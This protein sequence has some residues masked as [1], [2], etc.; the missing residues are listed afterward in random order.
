[1]TVSEHGG[2]S[3]SASSATA[4]P[5]T[6]RENIIMDEP[7]GLSRDDA[8]PSQSSRTSDPDGSF[9]VSQA[10]TLSPMQDDSWTSSDEKDSGDRRMDEQVEEEKGTKSRD[11]ARTD[12]NMSIAETLSLPREILFVL[13]I[14]LA[15]LFTQSG[16]GQTI[17]IIHTIGE[18]FGITNPGE[19]SWFMA[20]YSLTIGTFI[21]FSGRL[22][23]VFGHKTL[24]LYGMG[25]Y[26]I[27]SIVCG[28]SVY[29][30]HVL[31]IFA[32]VLQ[33]IGPAIILP[34]GLAILGVTYA[35]GRRKEMIFAIFGA[36]APTGSVIGSLFAA[37]LALAWWPWAFWAF[38]IVLAATVVIGYYAI[39]EASNR[40]H[41]QPKGFKNTL[42]ELDLIGTV[43]GVGGLVLVNFAWNQAPVVGWDKPYVYVLLIVG[44]LL[45]AA[46]FVFELK[47]AQYP[48]IP[49]NAFSYEVSFVLAAIACGWSC[50]GIWFFYSWEFLLVLRRVPPLLATAMFIPT[51]IS[52]IFA[53]LFTGYTLHRLRPPVVMTMALV[54]FTTGIII[55][56]TCPVEQ[57]YWGQY[58]V[59]GIIMPWGM[60]MSFPAATLILSDAV[61]RK[62]QGIAASLVNTV[63][64]YSISL[65]L[66]FAGTVETQV[67]KGGETPGD[68][69]KGYRGA[70]YMGI[71]LA[72]VGVLVCIAFVAKSKT[73]KNTTSQDTP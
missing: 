37:I 25:W 29:S 42:R 6:N 8:V 5:V 30:N 4:A 2:V 15:Q 63:V 26:S 72:S 32:R 48:L 10:G 13:V 50:F 56:A 60:D 55:L 21:L 70:Y 9:L 47:F 53:A 49:F 23:D 58:F 73:R 59:S 52:G 1:M 3:S 68:I 19:L 54:F 71:G 35:P 44:L 40:H 17:S 62:H 43:L 33:G 61:P 12:T 11:L 22:G 38:G 7:V 45:L 65:G 64:N 51:V 34:N 36:M 27:W 67:N 41:A 18:H 16:L 46:F 24:F 69:L 57:V 20:G 14:C 39:P 28:L 31:F 66:G